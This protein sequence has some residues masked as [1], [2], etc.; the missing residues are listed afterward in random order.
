MPYIQLTRGLQ[1]L[2]DEDDFEE[3]SKVKWLAQN[4]GGGRFYAARAEYF[5]DPITGVKKRR[6]ELMHRRLLPV[7]P[8]HWVDHKNRDTLDNRRSNLRQSTPSQNGINRP[9]H[10]NKK[11]SRYRGVAYVAYLNRKNPWMAFLNANGKRTYLGYFPDE[12]TAAKAHD[13]AAKELQGEFAQLNFPCPDLAL[14]TTS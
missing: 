14:L 2:V 6:Y 12:L 4:C 8:G 1:C 3:L 11:L 7:P 10:K 5:Y 9:P 13:A